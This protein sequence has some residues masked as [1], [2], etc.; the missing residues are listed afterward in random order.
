MNEL[1]K[2]NINW[3]RKHRKKSTYYPSYADASLESINVYM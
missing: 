2:Y 1:K 3:D